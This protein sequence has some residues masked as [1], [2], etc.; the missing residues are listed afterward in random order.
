MSASCWLPTWLIPSAGYT[1]RCTLMNVNVTACA[2]VH[3][4]GHV[5]V[6][7]SRRHLTGNGR[8][9]NLRRLACR[10]YSHRPSAHLDVGRARRF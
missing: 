9:R 6:H 7:V 10:H 5:C 3:V 4:C 2:C 1:F 8:A